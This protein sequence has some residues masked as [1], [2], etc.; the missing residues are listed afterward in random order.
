MFV[1]SQA[2]QNMCC[3]E[4]GLV[5]DRIALLSVRNAPALLQISEVCGERTRFNF[6]K[7][8]LRLCISVNLI[9]S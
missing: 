7:N 4:I 6:Q 5:I 2:L 1:I 8:I 9:Q 3:W